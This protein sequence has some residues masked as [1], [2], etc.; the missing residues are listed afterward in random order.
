M[1]GKL[2]NKNTCRLT[3]ARAATP[4]SSKQSFR[5]VSGSEKITIGIANSVRKRS[6]AALPDKQKLAFLL[7]CAKMGFLTFSLFRTVLEVST[8]L[9]EGVM[10]HSDGI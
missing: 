6:R 4:D 5:R 9:P 10:L 3:R 1:I 2:S 8:K 7:F